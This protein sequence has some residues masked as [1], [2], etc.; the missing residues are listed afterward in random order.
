MLRRALGAPWAALAAAVVSLTLAVTGFALFK[1]ELLPS[2][3][4]G[5]FVLGVAGPPGTSLPV[6][7]DYGRRIT[8]DLLAIDGVQSVEQQVGRSEGGEDAFGTE[9]SEF[10]VELRP[11]L[12][13]KRQDE[14]QGGHPEGAGELSRPA[15][16]SVDL[17]GRPN[18]RVALRRDPPRSPSGVFGADADT[19]ERTAHEIA[20]RA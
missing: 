5:H 6:M 11:K 16:R 3:R 10:H 19:L 2:F 12:S 18:R 17:P 15:D 8:R 13:G 1:Q 9:K 7:R 20:S 4:E 14:I